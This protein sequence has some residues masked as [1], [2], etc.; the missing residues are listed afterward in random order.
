MMKIRSDT[1][2]VGA[3]ISGLLAG[4]M[5]SQAGID[6]SVIEKSRGVGGRMAT[7][8]FKEGVFDHG[9]QFFTVRE[10]GFQRWVDLWIQEGVVNLW[11]RSF[12]TQDERLKPEGNPRFRGVNGMTTIAKYLSPDLNINLRIT[13]KSIFHDGKMWIARTE[14]GEE[15][16]ADHVI[17]TAPV[18]QSLKL[19]KAGGVSIPG[20][21][22]DVLQ[23]I[24]YHPCIALLVLLDSPSR[25]PAPGGMKFDSGPIQWIGDNSQKGIS[26]NAAAVTIH[27]SPDF[28]Q[29]NFDLSP[30][31]LVSSLILAAEPWLGENIQDWQIHKWRFSQPKNIYPEY[32]LEIPG[33]RGLYMAGDAF[34]GPR[35]EG[36]ALSGMAAAA[37]LL[38]KLS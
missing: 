31:A 2:V 34:G 37:H 9:A 25:V 15:I 18:P 22:L 36:A 12:K 10:P 38:E 26:P 33:M 32:F 5:L 6:V 35:V 16:G 21:E 20:R 29:E 28:S 14:D 13:V 19:L 24:G 17:L 30:E 1:L 23:N 7:R 8:R 11:A 3:G 27:A 4:K